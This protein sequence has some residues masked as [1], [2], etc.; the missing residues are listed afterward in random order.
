MNRQQ[1][2]TLLTIVFYTLVV[3]TLAAYFLWRHTHPLIFM[4]TG[5][6]AIVLRVATYIARYKK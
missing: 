2:D 6:V 4:I 3:L 5:V 1:W